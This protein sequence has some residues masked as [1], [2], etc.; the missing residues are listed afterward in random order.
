MMSASLIRPHNDALLSYLGQ[1]SGVTSP[2]C[3]YGA[4][5]HNK[6]I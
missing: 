5:L 1:Q 4:G 2:P 6:S 3:V